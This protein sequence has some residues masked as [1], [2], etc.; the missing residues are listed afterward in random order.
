[1]RCGKELDSPNAANADYVMADDTAGRERV[2][3]VIR[4]QKTVEE[5][6]AEMDALEAEKAEFEEMI[7]AY[8]KDGKEPGD[9]SIGDIRDEL[10][11]I[12]EEIAGDIDPIK[13]IHLRTTEVVEVQKTGIICPDCYRDTDMIIWGVHKHQ[14]K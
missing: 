4:R 2:P 11:A 10:E 9:L 3:K 14:G 5:V 8:E 13:T 6:R 7:T 12:E 1:M